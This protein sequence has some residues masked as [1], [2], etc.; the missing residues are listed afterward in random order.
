ME[1]QW[2]TKPRMDLQGQHTEW[3]WKMCDS[4]ARWWRRNFSMQRLCHAAIHGRVAANQTRHPMPRIRAELESFSCQQVGHHWQLFSNRLD[5]AMAE[6]EQWR[7]TD[8]AK[9]AVCACVRQ[10][11]YIQTGRQP[12]TGLLLDRRCRFKVVPGGWRQEGTRRSGSAI[13]ARAWCVG[14]EV[15]CDADS[16][17]AHAVYDDGRQQDFRFSGWKNRV[18]SDRHDAR[19][20][21][22]S[23]GFRYA[24]HLLENMQS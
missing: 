11:F 15:W 21:D 23:C 6:R 4:H 9:P 17:N 16:T 13:G 3:A 1:M 10:N 22:G 5:P 19:A 8:N 20:R 2:C 14:Y 7:S 12:A 24:L 18:H